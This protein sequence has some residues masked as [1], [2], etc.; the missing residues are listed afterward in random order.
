MEIRP[1][2]TE[3]DYEA[4]LAEIERIFDAQPGSEQGD[5]KDQEPILGSRSRAS[6]VLNRK[7]PLSMRMIR[8]LAEKLGISAQVLIQEYPLAEPGS[9]PVAYSPR[10]APAHSIAERRSDPDNSS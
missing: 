1:L 8:N 10:S 7:R 4:A 9:K 5:R 2:R 3:Q 6:E